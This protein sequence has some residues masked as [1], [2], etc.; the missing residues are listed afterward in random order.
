MAKVGKIFT[1]GIFSN[2]NKLNMFCLEK[3]VNYGIFLKFGKRFRKELIVKLIFVQCL[4]QIS[5]SIFNLSS[6]LDLT[7]NIRKKCQNMNGSH[8]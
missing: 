7:S 4:T 3:C 6:S 5:S 8:D 2:I 1:L